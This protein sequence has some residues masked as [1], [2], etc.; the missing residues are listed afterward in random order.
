MESMGV[1]SRCD[2]K[3]VHRFPHSIIITYPFSCI[4]S[5]WLY[6][7][8]IFVHLKRCF[9]FV[10]FVLTEKCNILLMRRTGCAIST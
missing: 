10:I 8:L 3:D 4:C 1:A 2:V 7:P 9:L 5:F 6:H